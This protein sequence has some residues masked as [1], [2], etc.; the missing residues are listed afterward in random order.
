VGEGFVAEAATAASLRYMGV[1]SSQLGADRLRDRGF[2]VQH[3]T[4]PPFPAGT[5]LVDLLYAS[6][7]IEHLRGPAEVALLLEE[8]RDLLQPG[9]RVA[10]VFPDARWMGIDFWDCDY[11]HQWPST[12]RRVRQVARDSGYTVTATYHCCLHL[13]GAAAFPLRLLY[14]LFPANWL[15]TLDR[16]REDLWYRGKM[17]FVPDTLM[18]LQPR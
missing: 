2:E 12:P 16:R 15:G 6:H 10:L 13:H 3:A 4:I 8:A 11:T 17:L 1:E 18:V 5:E 14:R 9:G 7:V